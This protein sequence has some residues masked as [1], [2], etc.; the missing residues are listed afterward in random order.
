MK[1]ERLSLHRP[2]CELKSSLRF[3]GNRKRDASFALNGPRRS[4]RSTE[5]RIPMARL[6]SSESTRKRVAGLA[7]EI[8]VRAARSP[9]S[10]W[11]LSGVSGRRGA[12]T[13]VQAGKEC[14]GS[15]ASRKS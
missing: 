4:D 7:G 5:E 10:R 8:C 13:S 12:A 1:T 11:Q 9:G 14:R 3:A 15:F 2:R 6:P